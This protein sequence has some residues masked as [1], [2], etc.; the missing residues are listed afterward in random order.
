LLLYVHFLYIN[1]E[2]EPRC[3][4]Q[5]GYYMDN[6][7]CCPSGD[8]M[9]EYN[10]D[11]YVEVVGMY[12]FMVLIVGIGLN[13]ALAYLYA[14]KGQYKYKINSKILNGL[15]HNPVVYNYDIYVKVFKWWVFTGNSFVLEEQAIEFLN[16]KRNRRK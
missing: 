15:P 13:V 3:D 11:K 12:Y 16:S 9:E 4:E 8:F 6:N 5:M 7:Q 10:D 1:Q 2:D 14:T